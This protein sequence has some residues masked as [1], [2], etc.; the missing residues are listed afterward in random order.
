MRGEFS[1]RGGPLVRGG[2]TVGGR[3]IDPSGNSLRLLPS[4][5]DRVGEAPVRRRPPGTAYHAFGGGG[6]AEGE[7]K[8]LPYRRTME[9]AAKASIPP[10]NPSARRRC[11]ALSAPARRAAAVAMTTPTV[12]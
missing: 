6:Q 11:V 7:W 10:A 12:P 5:P 8:V 1:R 3:T 9:T 4:G 2:Q